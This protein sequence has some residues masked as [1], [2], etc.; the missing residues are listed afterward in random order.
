MFEEWVRS[1]GITERLNGD[2][3]KTALERGSPVLAYR[4]SELMKS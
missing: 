4:N 2:T 1:D 3:L